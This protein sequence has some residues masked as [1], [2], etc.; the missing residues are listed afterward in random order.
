VLLIKEVVRT[1]SQSTLDLLRE[2]TWLQR[3]LY[4]GWLLKPV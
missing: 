4:F 1:L 2:A 3:I